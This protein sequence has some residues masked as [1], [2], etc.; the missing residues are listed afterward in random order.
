MSWIVTNKQDAALTG[1][2][3]EQDRVMLAVTPN[4][5]AERYEDHAQDSGA[6]A[7]SWNQLPPERRQEMIK[8]VD[9]YCDKQLLEIDNGINTIF[10]KME[11]NT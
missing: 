5:V 4:Y 10:S 11:Q 2:D 9:V 8:A 7:P 1:A 6:N 3:L